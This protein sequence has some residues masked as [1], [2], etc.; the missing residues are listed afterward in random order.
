MKIEF[1]WILAFLLALL[2]GV[3]SVSVFSQTST[4]NVT[5]AWTASTDAGAS[6]N[7]Y[8]AAATGGP[9]TKINS[10]PVSGTTYVDTTVAVGTAYY[11]VARSVL[12]GVESI[13]SNEASAT[14]LPAPP[15]GCTATA[16]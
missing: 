4:H 2:L 11:Y 9:Y 14:V 7:V 5:L 1:R 16:K 6:Y 10:L 15:T 8:R 13:N 3:L 12:N